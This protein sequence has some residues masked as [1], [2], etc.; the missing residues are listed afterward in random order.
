MRS[1]TSLLFAVFCL[2]SPAILAQSWIITNARIVSMNP[3][4]G[5]LEKGSILVSDGRIETVSEGRLTVP[6]VPVI[7]AGGHIVTPGLFDSG[8]QLG[9]S[10]VESSAVGTDD[11]VRDLKLG[12][13]FPVWMAL[14]RF[15]GFVPM[16]RKE[17]VTRAMVVP[18]TGTEIFA[19]QSALV[20]LDP[21]APFVMSRVN[22]EHL[23]LREYDRGLAGGSQA[24]ALLQAISS[25]EEARR[26]SRN[27]RAYRSGK[28]G[29]FRQ[30][31][32]D[33]RSLKLVL[34]RKIPLVVHVDRA[35]D[36]EVILEE[37]SGFHIRVVLSGAR[38]AWKVRD[39]IAAA[40]VPV[41]LNVMDN[42]PSRFDRLGARLDNAAILADAGIRIAFMTEDLYTETKVLTQGAG[43]AV[44]HGLSWEDALRAITVNPARIWGLDE[45]GEIAPGYVAD[46]VVWDGDPLEVM[47][48]PEKMMI[49]GAWVDL[50]SRQ[51]LLRDRYSNLQDQDIP[52]GYR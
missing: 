11:R 48:S 25:L 31:E 37:L 35:V 23:Y 15:S 14:N 16:I 39:R 38:E 12:A 7:D 27:I 24:S 45:Y 6:D 9:L 50:R 19:G 46:L 43:V 42:I 20:Q 5:I 21:G 44:A 2:L 32:A 1:L 26:Y 22:A 30:S 36:I 8:T 52:Y 4:T 10:E 41:L 49:N 51:D 18:R 47:S 13:G 33:L 28:L 3:Q 40:S 17:G 29:E 34:E